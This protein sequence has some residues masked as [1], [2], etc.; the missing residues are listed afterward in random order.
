MS[1]AWELGILDEINAHDELDL[2]E[3]AA[4]RD[5][6]LASVHALVRALSQE[7]IVVVDGDRVTAGPGFPEFFRTKGLFRWLT[8]GYG[9][10]FAQLATVCRNSARQG[11]FV[12]RD[13]N[14]I[15]VGCHDANDVLMDEAFLDIID[16]LDVEMV[17]DLGCGS[18]ERL[19]SI[20]RHK[21]SARCVGVDIAKDAID[22]ARRA[23]EDA[24]LTDRVSLIQGDVTGLLDHSDL[25]EADLIT[26]FLMGHDFWPRDRC[27][28]ILRDIRV[29]F[30]NLKC[31]LL[32]DTCRDTTTHEAGVPIFT[33]GFEVVHAVMGQYVPTEP[34]WDAL[35]EEAGW[36]CT[37]KHTYTTPP[38]T[39]VFQL[40]P[41]KG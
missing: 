15:S 41:E 17:A 7:D 40:E 6:H 30:P 33:L 18:G 25:V 13:A 28:R 26:C 22:L 11:D 39:V 23:V 5:L 16:D 3:F 36:K 14:A 24:G 38:R 4:V 29:N 27:V 37:R 1:A 20:A 9:A 8:G 35:F 12:R 32:G 31:F 19:V 10:M 21:P 2:A 34:E